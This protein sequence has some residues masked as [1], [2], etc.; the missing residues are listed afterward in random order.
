MTVEEPLS[1]D[2][3]EDGALQCVSDSDSK[4]ENNSDQI[5]A[6]CDTMSHVQALGLVT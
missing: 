2:E 4:S 5:C 3:D 6:S 1:D